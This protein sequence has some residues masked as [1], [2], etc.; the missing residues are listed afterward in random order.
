MQPQG[1][2]Q[3][4]LIKT[5]KKDVVVAQIFKIWISYF[6]S[7]RKFFSDNAGE[8]ANEVL[9][10]MNEKLGVETVTTAAESPFSNG[11]CERHNAIL[12]ETMAKRMEDTKCEPELA[13]A[14]AVSAKNALQNKSG[15]SPNQLAFGYNINLPTV[16]TDLPPALESTTSSDIVRRKPGCY[17]QSKSELYERRVK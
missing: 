7:P 16:L 11:I 15:F 4:V 5:K 3:H 2:L 10:E 8:F 6:G 1:I 12:F 14:W 17:A 13:L 9:R